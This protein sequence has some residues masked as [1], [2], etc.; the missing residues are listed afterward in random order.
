MAVSLNRYNHTAKR[1]LNKEVDLANIKLM[2]L[3]NTASF[4][5]AHTSVDQVAGAASPHRA[6]EV[7]G[8]GWAE[9]G[10]QFANLAVTI[11]NT[12][13][14][15]IDAD[16]ISKTATSGPIGPAYKGLILDGT[17]LF[18]LWFVSFGQLEEA[19]ENTDF[20]YILPAN[21]LM[22]SSDA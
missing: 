1:L 22:I 13:D 8:N 3:D 19:G 6:K 14:A 20:K 10:E 7:Y 18:P 17:N 16:D 12:D 4:T 15:K 2:L 5:G 21:G 9:G 11:V